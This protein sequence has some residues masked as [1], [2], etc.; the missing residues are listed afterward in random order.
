MLILASVE[1]VSNIQWLKDK[2]ITVFA[3]TTCGGRKLYAAGIG[4]VCWANL[5]GRLLGQIVYQANPLEPAVLGLPS[6]H[7][8]SCGQSAAGD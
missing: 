1:H 3:V 4:G 7:P 8:N 2:R 5:L 6:I